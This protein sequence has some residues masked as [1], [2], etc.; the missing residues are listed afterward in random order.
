MLLLNSLPCATAA[1]T[2]A[3]SYRLSLRRATHPR[4]IHLKACVDIPHACSSLLY[5][6]KYKFPAE[7][8]NAS[9]VQFGPRPL[10]RSRR[11]NASPYSTRPLFSLQERPRYLLPSQ[12]FQNIRHGEDNDPPPVHSSGSSLSHT[13]PAI[14]SLK[15]P[16]LYGPRTIRSQPH[17]KGASPEVEPRSGTPDIFSRVPLE[18]LKNVFFHFHLAFYHHSSEAHSRRDPAVTLSSVCRHWRNIAR[19][20]PALWSILVFDRTCDPPPG[21][22]VWL[23]DVFCTKLKLYAGLSVPVP[24]EIILREP[25]K[26]IGTLE[27]RLQLWDRFLEYLEA[28]EN[29]VTRLEILFGSRREAEH[30]LPFRFPL[31]NLINLDVGWSGSGPVHAGREV[32]LVS[33]QNESPLQ[34]LVLRNGALGISHVLPGWL[35]SLTCLGVRTLES[36][37]PCLR[38]ARNLRSLALTLQDHSPELRNFTPSLYLPFLDRLDVEVLP[39]LSSSSALFADIVSFDAPRLRTLT[40]RYS[41]PQIGDFPTLKGLIFV[42]KYASLTPGRMENV[43]EEL[44]EEFMLYE[45]L[46]RV[47]LDDFSEVETVSRALKHSIHLK[48]HNSFD[49]QEHPVLVF[50]NAHGGSG[51]HKVGDAESRR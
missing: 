22:V 19:S 2:N 15:P 27:D 49:S 16:G 42:G 8:R 1:F 41:R 25:F 4:R 32:E 13:P 23:I 37:L 46:E 43:V 30:V 7:Y 38:K 20:Y 6:G 18:I 11:E 12:R 35:W 28:C 45:S 29:R 10:T 5:P 39:L 40:L 47:I 48:E 21:G 36:I 26:G 17:S 44:A 33:A 31:E 24:V 51:A 34:S 14:Q 3:T 50:R 9:Q